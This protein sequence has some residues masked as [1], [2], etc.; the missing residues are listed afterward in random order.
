MLSVQ[1]HL[2]PHRGT[3][4]GTSRRKASSSAL[5]LSC[6]SCN[7]HYSSNWH[8]HYQVRSSLAGPRWV[9]CSRGGQKAKGMLAAVGIE[10]L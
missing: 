4:N 9:G 7:P 10:G 1:Q 5:R 3:S 8:A 2:V 6:R